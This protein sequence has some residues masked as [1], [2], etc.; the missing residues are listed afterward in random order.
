MAVKKFLFPFAN[1]RPNLDKSAWHRLVKVLFFVGLPIFL[2]WSWIAIVNLE[3]APTQNCVDYI[4][5]FNPFQDMSH[6]FEL[7]KVHHIV[8]FWI[9][10]G[11]TLSTLYFLQVIYYKVILYII[12]GKNK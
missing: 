12:L 6:C 5:E 3:Y 1:Q 4:I 9:A 10:L 7:S 11:L 2:V 8:D